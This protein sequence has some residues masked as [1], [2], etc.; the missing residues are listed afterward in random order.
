MVDPY[1][2]PNTDVLKNKLGI[3]NSKELDEA[4]SMISAIKLI[5][6]DEVKGNFDYKHLMDIHKHIFGDIYDWAGEARIIDIEKSER[7]LAGA[8]VK[9]GHHNSISEEA[10]KAIN[11]L[12]AVKWQDLKSYDEKAQLFSKHL[13]RLWQVHPFR[14]GNT[15]TV[16]EFCV[17]YASTQNI[18]LDKQLFAKNPAFFRN[19]LVLASIGEYSEYSHLETIIKDSMQ[20]GDKMREEKKNQEKGIFSLNGLKEIDTKIKSNQETKNIDRYRSQK[21]DKDERE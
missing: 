7:V 15:R 6:V 1:I 11:D 5:D 9:Y 8:S 21:L 2:I 3:T 20:R 18:Y 4:E 12:K 13:A 17:Q 16:T 14:E 19:S 10:L